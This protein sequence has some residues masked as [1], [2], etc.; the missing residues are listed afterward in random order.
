LS[1]FKLY[2][3]FGQLSLPSEEFLEGDYLKKIGDKSENVYEVAM[4]NI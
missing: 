3:S 2:E 4:E 1:K